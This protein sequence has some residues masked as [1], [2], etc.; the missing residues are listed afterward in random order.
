[1]VASAGVVDLP[2]DESGS[3]S[4]PVLPPRLSVPV[5]YHWGV[6]INVRLTPEESQQLADLAAFEGR[7][8][9]QVITELI[10]KQWTHNY[11]RESAGRALDDI[12]A[13]RSDLMD[14]LKDA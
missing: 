3:C 9:Q 7:S 4:T 8:K 13:Q 6:G 10:R 14:R 11:A 2:V 5:R 1:M 12:F